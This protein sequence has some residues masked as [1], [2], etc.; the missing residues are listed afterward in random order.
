MDNPYQPPRTP[1]ERPG[2][3]ADE[4]SLTGDV[5]TFRMRL[6]WPLVGVIA[7]VSLA[8]SVFVLP[9]PWT[10]LW[11]WS[12]LAWSVGATM[13]ILLALTAGLA[14]A[15]PISVSADGIRCFDFWGRYLVFR[16][17]EIHRASPVSFCGLTYLRL[18]SPAATRP[19]WLPLFLGRAEQF[20][21]YVSSV[22]PEKSAAGQ[23][24]RSWKV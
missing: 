23:A 19:M 21:D 3:R 15:F 6:T 16:W 18:Y 9:G 24:I 4:L 10:P 22:A 2:N 5:R 12:L 13:V 8:N 11:T 20:R 7:S 1:P 17:S 14:L